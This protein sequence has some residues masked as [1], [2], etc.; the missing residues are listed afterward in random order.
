MGNKPSKS[1]YYPYRIALKL[2]RLQYHV[3][4]VVTGTVYVSV[5]DPVRLQEMIGDGVHLLFEGYENSEIVK[6]DRNPRHPSSADRRC[7]HQNRKGQHPYQHVYRASNAIVRADYGPVVKTSDLKLLDPQGSNDGKGYGYAFRWRLPTAQLPGSMYCTKSSHE[8]ATSSGRTANNAASSS[9]K[10]CRSFAEIRY[11]L[12]AYLALRDDFRV[13]PEF[14]GSRRP[15]EDDV[16]FFNEVE[17]EDGEIESPPESQVAVCITAASAEH[18]DEVR[19]QPDQKPPPLVMEIDQFPIRSC[20]WFWKRYGEIDLGW[21]LESGDEAGPGD[22]VTVHVYGRNRSSMHVDSVSVRWIETVTW[23]TSDTASTC[24]GGH[25]R[26]YYDYAVGTSRRGSGDSYR[27]G[28]LLCSQSRVL[29]EHNI[30]TGDVPWW[31]PWSSS[32]DNGLSLDDTGGG[33]S[34]DEP[35]LAASS[36]MSASSSLEPQ[37]KLTAR[38][39][40]PLDARDSYSGRLVNVRHVLVVTGTPIHMLLLWYWVFPNDLCYDAMLKRIYSR[41]RYY[42]ALLFSCPMLLQP[43]RAV[44]C[45]HLRNRPVRFE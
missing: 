33:R 3:G 32:N 43:T 7:Q 42:P 1:P 21:G 24:I 40:L 6:D 39:Q 23:K 25:D 9:C 22:A 18:Y 4:D 13:H 12:T 44:V 20:P 5:Q 16:G 11:T 8:K 26:C 45:L 38:L 17:E 27:S 30:S 35:L 19:Q 36:T 31:Q 34:L 28:T 2:D 41:F 29:S 37:N 10:C 15:Y 14:H